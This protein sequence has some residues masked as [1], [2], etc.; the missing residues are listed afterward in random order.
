MLIASSAYRADREMS[1]IS[2]AP[3]YFCRNI[4]WTS[5]TPLAVALAICIWELLAKT[6]SKC[7]VYPIVLA[8]RPPL[9][10]DEAK[11]LICDGTP[12]FTIK[13]KPPFWLT[14][15]LYLVAFLESIFWSGSFILSF[16]HH[17]GSCVEWGYAMLASSWMYASIIP[18]LKPRYTPPYDLLLLY[19]TF[20]VS[21]IRNFG[22][23]LLQLWLEDPP[24][25]IVIFLHALNVTAISTLL[26]IVLSRPVEEP[27]DALMQNAAPYAPED[28]TVLWRWLTHAWI[29]PFIKQGTY[30]TLNEDDVPSLSVTIQAKPVFL[31]FNSIEGRSLSQKIFFANSLD[32][33]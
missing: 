25:N 31:K 22:D 12:S 13:K 30:N 15:V 24:S 23:V 11:A 20:E 3:P 16:I 28:T 6:S 10:T 9:S 2:T 19:F 5:A 14:L 8:L 26:L 1:L 18:I 21:A 29:S 33:M 17:D 32:L 4:L 27:S 7:F